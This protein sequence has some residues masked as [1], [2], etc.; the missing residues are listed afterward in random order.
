VWAEEPTPF[1]H[2]LLALENVV[3]TPHVAGASQE[4]FIAMA[5]AVADDVLRVLRGEPPANPY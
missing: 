2:P 4:A 5:E 3:A 1:D